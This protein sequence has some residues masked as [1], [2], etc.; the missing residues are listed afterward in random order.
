MKKI[1]LEYL[2]YPIMFI[3]VVIA[4]FLAELLLEIDFGRMSK[5][6]SGGIEF[7]DEEK[8]QILDV[9]TELESKISD[10]RIELDVVSIQLNELSRTDSDLTDFNPLNFE[11]AIVENFY[12]TQTVSDQTA[13]LG[14]E[15]NT[16][17]PLLINQEGYIFIGNYN[18]ISKKWSNLALKDL[19]HNAINEDPNELIINE[20]IYIVHGNMILRKQMPKNDKEYYK[21]SKRLGIV[22][23]HSIISLVEKPKG[24]DRE[25]A[26][27]WWVKIRIEK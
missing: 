6:G 5:I 23:D 16:K 12:K 26:V 18:R 21:G 27:Q 10:L 20:P 3:S 2:K 22:P 1:L 4:M 24:I 8:A 11:K 13:V 15:Q 25:F 19:N 14:I 9:N 17:E 7:Y